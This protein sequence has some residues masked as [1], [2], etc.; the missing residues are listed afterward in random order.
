MRFVAI[1]TIRVLHVKA[2][3]R[4]G[5]DR[6]CR[7]VAGRAEILFVLGQERFGLTRMRYVTLAAVATGRRRMNQA[8]VHF[9]LQ[10]CVT[11]DTESRGRFGGQRLKLR[12][13]RFM[14]IEAL[15]VAKR[16]V[17]YRGFLQISHIGMT[18]EAELVTV[19]AE[20]FGEIR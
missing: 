15:A 9:T 3:V 19:V 8:L 6:A 16:L 20:K 13:M 10:V 7:I 4:F 17:L 1:L 11:T 18:R 5:K 14:A 12:R 2:V